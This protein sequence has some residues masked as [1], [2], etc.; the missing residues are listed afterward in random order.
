M[1]SIAQIRPRVVERETTLATLP[2]LTIATIVLSDTLALLA[3]ISLGIA[4]R[5]AFGGGADIQ[6][7]VRLWPFLSVFLVVYGVV[8]LYPAIGMTPPDEL[9]RVMSSTVVL[10]YGMA[11]STMAFRGASRPVTPTLV[12]TLSLTVV[13]IPLMRALTRRL[14]AERWWWGY[15]AVVFGNSCLT[16]SVVSTLK[17]EPELGLKPVAVVGPESHEFAGVPVVNVHSLDRRLGR[18]QSYTYAMMTTWED[19]TQVHRD[20]EDPQFQRLIYVQDTDAFC[21]WAK[22]RVLGGFLGVEVRQ[23][24]LCRGLQ[25]LKRALD[26]LLTILISL[27]ALPIIAWIAVAIP[28][29]SSGPV[30]FCHRRL[31]RGGRPFKAWKFRTMV[32]NAEQVLQAY[33]KQNPEMRVEWE[34][35]QKLRH[36]PRVTRLGR[37]I[38]KFS[39]DELPQLWNVVTGDMSLVGPRPIVQAEVSRYGRGIHHY[40]AVT[41]GLTGLWQVSGRND[42]SYDERVRLDCFYVKNWSVCLD[43]CILF[44][45][46]AVVLLRKGAY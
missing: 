45:T 31:G 18:A 27:I 33:L 13:L 40:N 28:L 1:A 35:D 4:S 14:F 20:P 12:I 30:F 42:T 8:G 36:D 9:R 7:Y 19:G 29:D 3:A 24:H 2:S 10:F 5:Y 21:M 6:S 46:F 23:L 38:R 32:P 26:I 11:A 15:P 22:P 34:R 37:I 25:C 43:L 44:R 17:K 39:L 41:G 16:R